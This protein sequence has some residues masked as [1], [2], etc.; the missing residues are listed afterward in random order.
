MLILLSGKLKAG[1]DTV[2]KYLVEEY[3][4]ERFAFA[5]KLK[6]LAKDHFNW[7]G[8]KDQV[9]RDLLIAI[10]NA[11][12]DLD[13]DAWVNYVKRKIAETYADKDFNIVISDTRYLNELNFGK[14]WFGKIIRISRDVN[15]TPNERFIIENSVSETQLD[16][17]EFDYYLD[18]N[19]SIEDLHES[20]D[21]MMLYFSR[22]QQ[23]VIE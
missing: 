6:E 13:Q 3:G 4:F 20:I 2:A 15:Y 8:E 23:G 19:G 12:R 11:V 17:I 21:K 10:G 14:D 18:N 22:Q 5:D 1:K 16:N 9:G 7:N